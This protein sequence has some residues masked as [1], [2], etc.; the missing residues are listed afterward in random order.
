MRA[1]ACRAVLDRARRPA[2]ARCTSTSRCASRS[3]STRRCRRRSPAAAAAP[4]GRPWVA[5]SRGR[6]DAAPDALRTLARDR[7]AGAARRRRRRA[8][9]AR[10]RRSPPPSARFAAAAG[11]PVLAD[12]LVRRAPRRRRA[13]AH[14]DALL[15]DSGFAAE[16]RPRPGRCASATCRPRSRCARGSRRSTREQVALD[17]EGAWHDPAGVVDARRSPPTRRR[18]SRAVAA[19]RHRRRRSR[20]GSTRW[21]DADAR[22]AGAIAATLGDGAERAARRGARSSPR[23]RPRRRSSSPPRCRSA[24]S[25]RSAPARDD[26]AARARQPRRQRHRRHASRPRYGVAAAAR[27]PG[28]RCCIG[29]V[30]LAHDLGGLLA[31]ARAA[32]PDLTIVVLDNDGGGIFDFLPVATPDRRLREHVATPHAASTSRARPRS[33][34][35]RTSRSPTLE[36]LRA[37]LAPSSAP[38]GRA[39]PRPHRARGRTSRC[40]ARSGRPSRR[41]A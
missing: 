20:P 41:A 39:D 12:P 5:R 31:G 14:Y 32:A 10:R 11:Y 7:R 1:L 29:D 36:E 26:A 13:I 28:R 2:R 38:T 4:D 21:R 17:P 27:G 16:Q 34:G 3:C 22:A 18:R 33:T 9:R 25:R 24:T 35:A 8:R 23:C 37:A 6:R 40:T 19:A 15:R 30:A